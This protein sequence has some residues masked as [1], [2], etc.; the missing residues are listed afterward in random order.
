MS[1]LLRLATSLPEPL[2]RTIK[3]IPGSDWLRA[4][5]ADRPK[6]VPVPSGERRTVVYLPTWV[7]W[8]VMRQRPQ[9]LLAAFG[10]LGFEVVFVDPDEKAPRTV[11][12]V[13]IVPSV[14]HAPRS[15]VILYTHFA[16]IRRLVDGFDDAVVVYDLLDDLSIY[17]EQ[18]RGIPE[19]RRVRAHHPEL[20][21]RADAV[22]ASNRVLVDRHLAERGDILLV[23]NG[24][25]AA[26]FGHP[27]DAPPDLG[28]MGHPI[29]GYHGMISHWF[30]FDLF[31]AT[32]RLAP[33]WSF[34]LVGPV[35]EAVAGR[36]EEVTALPNVTWLG[37]RPSDGMPAYVQHF[38]VGV[39]WFV[40]DHLTEGVTPLKMFELLAAGTPCV[41]TPLPAA[42]EEPA[43][44]TASEAVAM[45]AAIAEALQTP[46]PELRAAGE[47]A[48]WTA[49]L[50][51]LVDLLEAE[52][53]ARA[54]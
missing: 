13:R 53:L 54:R 18:E 38:D 45:V 1:R 52:G 47:A 15:G 24:V 36:L 5:I 8:D 43:V 3:S 34:V 35:D 33:E 17:D 30:D 19:R 7:H 14:R 37:E 12:G 16:P 28:G 39:I 9:Y 27:V 50:R 23:E 25:D 6:G 29:V 32:A 49:R 44:A 10:R 31:E 40:V 42:L 51:P 26:R 21:R 22:I 2:R 41:S 46:A 20:M 48:D 11:D 4:I